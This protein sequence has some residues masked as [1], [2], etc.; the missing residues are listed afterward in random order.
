LP[1]SSP[2]KAIGDV[3]SHPSQHANLI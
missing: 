2:T 3:L 1:G